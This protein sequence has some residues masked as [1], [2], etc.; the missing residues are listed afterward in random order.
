MVMNVKDFSKLLLELNEDQSEYAEIEGKENLH[1]DTIGDKASFIRHVAALANNRIASYLIIGVEDSTWRSIG[2][3]HGSP[4][5]ESDQTERRMNSILSK[6]IDPSIQVRYRTYEVSG[7]FFGLVRIEGVQPPYIISI[8]DM[9]YGGERTN[10]SPFH[11]Y[12]G[13]I[14]R[15]YGAST[16][17]V[18]RQSEI[19][20]IVDLAH[21]TS[22]N[23][24]VVDK[25]L[26]SFNYL[27]V[28]SDKFG[29]HELTKELMET[30]RTVSDQISRSYFPAES[31]VSFLIYP[32]KEDCEID[33]VSLK[34]KLIPDQR[35]GR[36]GE[37]Y[38]GIPRFFPEMLYSGKGTPKEYL[39][40]LEFQHEDTQGITSF[41]RIKPSGYIEIACAY[42]IVEKFNGVTVYYFVNII[43]A[44]WQF[45]YLSKAIYLE[46]SFRGKILIQMNLIG[47]R[48]SMLVQY[49]RSNQRGGWLSPF[50]PM[51]R[52]TKNDITQYA[53]IQISEV[54]DL[55]ASSD[56][57][58]EDVIRSIAKML[59][60]YYGHEKPRCF[61]VKTEEFP[62][63][64]YRI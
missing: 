51:Y 6:R 55:D 14:F 56:E 45:I 7:K 9:S 43:G 54:L 48:D 18:N 8:E 39:A 63:R 3:P 32:H 47:S 23:V 46:A 29:R 21:P 57:D 31:W 11:I 49:S 60:S 53:N 1:L 20:S 35:I 27:D 19:M 64:Q 5:L 41:L 4:L 15:R 17:I 34:E 30:H 26:A 22:E 33:T 24:S 28:D 2:I 59:G 10:S 16:G 37:A 38:N 62:W 40:S 44:I 12:R 36:G 61:D 50:D 58:I 52:V 42:P 25:F 13:S